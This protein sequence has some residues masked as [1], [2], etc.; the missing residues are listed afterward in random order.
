MRYSQT[1][2]SNFITF[3]GI[4]VIIANQAGFILDKNTVAFVFASLFTLIS[5][6]YNFYQRFKK[7]DISLIGYMIGYNACNLSK[8]RVIDSLNEQILD[9]GTKIDEIMQYGNKQFY[10]RGNDAFILKEG[11]MKK[12]IN[13]DKIMK[14]RGNGFY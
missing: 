11:K 5:T 1:Q 9:K 7:G 10:W 3:A 4:I 12:V 8:N 2:L 14:L 13:L 6:A